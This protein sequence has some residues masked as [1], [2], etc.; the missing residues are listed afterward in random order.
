VR[1][2][3]HLGLVQ[4]LA[5][6]TLLVGAFTAFAGST[7]LRS[8]ART[9]LRE[10]IEARNVSLAD[11]LS[12]GVDDRVQARID[13]LT[14]LA[15]NRAVSGLRPE[16]RAEFNVALST[17]FYFERITLFDGSGQP[18][19]GAASR[20]LVDLDEL[21]PRPEMAAAI[22]DGPAI[23]IV[24]DPSPRLEIGIPVE[25][26]PGT[27]VG[28]L[29]ADMPMDL[30]AARVDLRSLDESLVAFVVDDRG[31]ILAH[32]DR[33]RVVRGE[34]VSLDEID[35]QDGGVTTVDTEDGPTLLA[36]SDSALFP[37]SIVVQQ[38]IDEAFAPVAE[39]I[40]QLTS[41]LLLVVLSTV[42][43]AA[44]VGR[45]I[46][47]PLVALGGVV[48]RFAKGDRSARAEVAGASE[49]RSLALEFNHMADALKEQ[50]DEL[51]TSQRRLQSILDN[52]T[53][54]I[55]VKDLEGR[56][57]LVN[58]RYEQDL[59]V[60]KDDVIGKRDDEFLPADMASTFRAND[61]RVLE[62]ARPMEVEE[63]AGRGDELK[64]YLSVKFPL[65]DSRGDAYAVCGISTDISELKKAEKY[66]QQILD[67]ERDRQRALEIN[68]NV[69]QGLTVA[70]MAMELQQDSKAVGVL[71]ETLA[72]ARSIISDL[73]NARAEEIGPGDLIRSTPASLKDPDEET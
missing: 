72:S 8:S 55:Y 54:V 53:A 39:S 18:V 27:P 68:D 10:Q 58:R 25:D 20:S 42:G 50:I 11:R 31:R 6:A 22:V 30:I 44:L 24:L 26:P 51:A 33:D 67:A 71:R 43:V 19:A 61:V 63:I 12:I 17:S 48:D 5:L 52:T 4:R 64:T 14:L 32:P 38:P 2:W 40:T 16:A 29:V 60:V 34:E 45:Q 49:T 57:L 13:S 73:L 69:I 1:N 7:V 46:L 36:A 62:E 70:L 56:Y 41:I 15:A 37:G 9:A 66:R 23:E 21:E 47:H 35:T 65:I 59:G 28:S 3:H